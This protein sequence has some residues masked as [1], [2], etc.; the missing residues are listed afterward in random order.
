VNDVALTNTAW[1]DVIAP[2]APATAVVQSGWWFA[3]AVFA[4]VAI[5]VGV[6]W[7]RPRQRARR[8]LQALAR[9]HIVDDARRKVAC[10]ELA[11]LLCAIHQAPR[12]ESIIVAPEY[13]ERWRAYLARLSAS[14]YGPQAPS[15]EG[16]ALLAREALS[17]PRFG[18]GKK[19]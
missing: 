4:V 16:F 11:R 9:T 3:L 1:I 15:V 14:R 8:A 12:V 6:W 10:R 19:A 17:Y 2:V 18:E 5:G 13:V 7:R